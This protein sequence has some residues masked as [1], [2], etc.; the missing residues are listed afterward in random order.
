MSVKF[1]QSST[2]GWYTITMPPGLTSFR[3]QLGSCAQ[4]QEQTAQMSAKTRKQI[5]VRRM[6]N[7]FC[8]EN[9]ASVV[10]F[11]ATG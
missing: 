2:C 4:A 10:S 5:L 8:R 1:C 11:L 6:A 7:S 9:A 3:G